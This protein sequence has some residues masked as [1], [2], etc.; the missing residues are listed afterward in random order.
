MPRSIEKCLFITLVCVIAGLASAP[1]RA[2][3]QGT[4][5]TR[6]LG[7]RVAIKGNH[8]RLI[9][10][11]EG[12]RPTQVGPASEDGISV[13]FTQMTAK[14]PDKKFEGNS[15]AAKDIKFRRESGFF[16]VL[17]R[18]KHTSAT[19]K[20]NPGKKAGKY[21]LVIELSAPGKSAAQAAEPAKASAREP[22]GERSGAEAPTKR[23]ETG[24]LFGSKSPPGLKGLLR[25][26][27]KKK[28]ESGDRS[29]G[30]KSQPFVAADERT[31]ALFDIANDRFES[32]RRNLVLCG[33]ELIEAYEEALKAGPKTSLAPV[34]FYRLGLAQWAMGN[35]AKA[36]RIFR[37][38]I[39]EWPDAPTASRCWIGLGDFYNK[40][41][42]YLEAME[43]FRTALRLAAD[44][45]DKAA[46]YF[47]LGREYLFLGAPREAI[48]LFEQCAGQDPWFHAKKPELV[49]LVGEA[50]FSLGMYDRSKE[51][52]LR[53]VNFQ[54]S[55][56]DQDIV[57]AKLAEILLNQG[58]TA[59]ANKVHLFINKYFT[60]SEGDVIS[61]I[62]QAELLERTDQEQSLR[63]YD[64]LCAKDLS[65]NLRKIV[66]FKLATLNWKNGN[67]DRSLQLMDDVFQGKTDA[68]PGGEMAGMRERIL[69][70]MVKKHFADKNYLTVIQLHDRYRRI[71]DSMQPA[72]EVFEDIAAS[73]GAMKFYSNAIELYERLM[74]KSQKK[75]E[76]QYLTCALYSLRM[77]DK[78]KS[79][80]FCKQVQA[81]ALDVRKSEV[82]GHICYLEQKYGD[83]VKH[84]S[85]ILQKQKEFDLCEPDS[86]RTYGHTLY[87]LKKYDEAIPILQKGFERIKTDDADNQRATLVMLGKCHMALKQ[88]VK[89]AET[90]ETALR[91][92]KEEQTNELLYEISKLYLVAGQPDKAV[93][94]LNLIIETQN[95]F[96]SA[97][98]QQ[99]INS[100]QMAQ[101]TQPR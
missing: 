59:L 65:P 32:C 2:A 66:Y 13:F 84:F 86:F 80:N 34:G 29:P 23:I 28:H 87:E 57:Y 81:E 74:A 71:F 26:E 6:I 67:L 88:Y 18:Q 97:I 76:E 96:W 99:Q 82:L 49:R 17:F 53:Y 89:A 37:H 40:K 72:S 68:S 24:E 46:A 31:T 47:E 22:A 4:A 43:A 51:H 75:N 101:T 95:P 27:E 93:Q 90:F 21:S 20:I 55:A 10:D 77:G 14:F 9:F 52:L 11:A 41:Q 73:Y 60:D 50:E 58:E 16:E 39:S 62:R 69:V 91:F 7:V 54:Q 45:T 15:G 61:R 79:S 44:K 3:E 8:T 42:A 70:E 98:A 85:K 1:V 35:Y 56:P 94:N 92:G 38:A 64:E 19:H 78:N 30:Q 100:I 83:A 12:A 63:I 5:A 33:P 25:A 48:E 36:E